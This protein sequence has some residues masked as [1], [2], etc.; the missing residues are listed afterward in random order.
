MPLVMGAARNY[1]NALNEESDA[2]KRLVIAQEAI[3]YLE[4]EP[5]LWDGVIHVAAYGAIRRGSVPNDIGYIDQRLSFKSKCQ[6][7]TYIEFM[8]GTKHVKALAFRFIPTDGYAESQ[9]PPVID[10]PVDKIALMTSFLTTTV[11]GNN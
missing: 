10:V 3:Q 4:N 2:Q 1:Q 5:S 8:H 6:Q 7:I 11:Y 9:E